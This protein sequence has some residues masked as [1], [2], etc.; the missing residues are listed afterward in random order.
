MRAIGL[1]GILVVLGQLILGISVGAVALWVQR[2]FF[3][4]TDEDQSFGIPTT[5]AFFV[6]LYYFWM[7]IQIDPTQ[8]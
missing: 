1:V 2:R 3:L 4:H 6:S 7:V 5:V 8:F